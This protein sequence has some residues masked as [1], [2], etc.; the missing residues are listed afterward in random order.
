MA[1]SPAYTSWFFPGGNTISY[2]Y[3]DA[4]AG[5]QIAGNQQHVYGQSS[6]E[7]NGHLTPSPGAVYSD[8]EMWSWLNLFLGQAFATIFCQ[9]MSVV[10][11]PPEFV[12]GSGGRSFNYLSNI[13]GTPA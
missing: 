8:S 3:V 1:N 11:P 2:P 13:G 5:P 7:I 6:I 9:D 12:S 10:V 4:I